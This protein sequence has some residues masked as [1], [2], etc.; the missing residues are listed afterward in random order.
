[1]TVTA[2][3]DIRYGEELDAA[4]QRAALLQQLGIETAAS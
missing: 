3:C 2:P 4:I 1:M